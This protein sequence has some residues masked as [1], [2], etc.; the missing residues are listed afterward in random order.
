M[1]EIGW[2]DALEKCEFGTGERKLGPLPLGWDSAVAISSHD[3]A[4]QQ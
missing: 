4:R 3:G 1:P 2:S